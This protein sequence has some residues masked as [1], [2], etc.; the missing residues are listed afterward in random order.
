MFESKGGVFLIAGVLFFVISFVVMGVLPWAIHAGERVQTV[1]E[2]AAQ[3]ILHEFVELR[4]RFPKQFTRY[5][6]EVSEASF[7][8]VLRLGRDVYVGEGCWHCH[9][10]QIRPVANE[11]ARWGPVSHARE[12]LNELQRPLLLGTRRVGPDLVREGALRSNDWHLAHFYKPSSVVPVS[13]MPDYKW[14]FDEEGVPNKRGMAIVTYVQW[15]GSWLD[16]YPY[17]LGGGPPRDGDPESTKPDD[18]TNA[19]TRP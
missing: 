18:G 11:E 14:F 17:F 15:M 2:I 3:G 4:E 8:E 16:E 10:Q 1:E 6:G 13:V 5:Y 19:E 7:A 12:Y 9:T